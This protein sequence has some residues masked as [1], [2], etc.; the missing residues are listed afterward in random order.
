MRHSARHA[1]ACPRVRRVASS[2]SLPEALAVAV[3]AA[4]VVVAGGTVVAVV[5]VAPRRK[6][7]S[8]SEDPPKPAFGKHRKR[9]EIQN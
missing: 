5:H 3:A 1:D 6:T 4:L 9:W 8:V 2:E 7:D